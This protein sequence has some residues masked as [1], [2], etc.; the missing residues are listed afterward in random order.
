M[1]YNILKTNGD[2]LV[3]IE[4]GLS[5]SGQSSIVL[6]GKNYTGYG[7]QLDENLVHMLENFA[8]S[9]AP[10]NPLEG[11]LWWDT[12]SN[13]MKVRKAGAWKVIGGSNPAATA[14]ASD[15]AGDLWWDTTNKQLFVWDGSDWRLTGP[16]Y[17]TAQQQAGQVVST[18]VDTLGNPHN[19]VKFFLNNTVVAVLSKDPTFSVNVVP[20]FAVL[21]PGFN[22]PSGSY[23]YVGNAEN[24]LSLGGIPAA[25]YLRS[26]VAS[27]S[28]YPLNILNDDGL[29]IGVDSDFTIKVQGNSTALMNNI[30]GRDLDFYVKIG[31]FETIALRISG[32]T[33]RLQ[34]SNGTVDAT[35]VADKQYVDSQDQI[36]NDALIDGAPVDLNTLSKLASALGDD[37]SFASNNTAAHDLLAPK[38]N[39]TFTGTVSAPTP[40]TPANNAEVATTEFVNNKLDSLATGSLEVRT[41]TV[42]IA[43]ISPIT[44]GTIDAGTGISRFNTVYAVTFAGTA[45]EAQ[46]A[47]LAENYVADAE[48]EDGTVLDFGGAHEVTLSTGSVATRVAGVVSTNPA[49]LMNSDCKGHF[50]SAVALQGRCPV[51][52]TG[53]IQKGDLL[54]SAGN[55]RAKAAVTPSVGS[56]IGK[57]LEDFDGSD[58]VIEVSVGRC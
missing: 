58:G 54:V 47:D 46:Y 49:Y 51:K 14:P 13:L 4:D 36:T 10:Q 20:G 8:Y 7:P 50:V 21:R 26:D 24:A 53:T 37:A 2:N 19:I 30:E 57:A 32:T 3:T 6:F 1:A 29:T 25:N 15:V 39:P 16:A 55:G 34:L 33:G 41:L 17:T 11:Q 22:L 40:A 56:V 27:D 35:D 52:V 23:E 38:A 42:G 12:T 5:D 28:D 48:Y 44:D 18:I 9:S 43:G 31:G 45:L